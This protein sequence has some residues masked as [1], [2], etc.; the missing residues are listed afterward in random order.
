MN[1]SL[2][3]V[4]SDLIPKSLDDVVRKNRELIEMRLATEGEIQV[5]EKKIESTHHAKDVIEDWR[6]VCLCEKKTN[7]VQ[8]TL[9]G[10]STEHKSSWITSSI[11]SIDFEQK[12]VLTNSRSIYKLGK[13]GHGEP[14]AEHLMHVCAAL[15]LWGMGTYLGAPEFFY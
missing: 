10:N 1:N 8:L 9:L 12:I 5:L 13:K 4:I 11:V 6:I 15:H 7:W 14:P 2:T 3:Q